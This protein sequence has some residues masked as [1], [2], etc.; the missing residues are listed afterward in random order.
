[1]NAEEFSY[2]TTAEL[3]RLVAAGEVTPVEL[4][5]C[6]IKRIEERNPSI[7]A[8]IYK[9]Y[10]TARAEAK[11]AE[12]AVRS[13]AL[14]GVLHGVPTLMKDLFDFKPGWKSTMGGIPALKDLVI[15]AYCVWAERV[16]AAGGIIVG[17]TNSPVMG[18]RGVTDNPLFGAT[19][20]PFDATRN[21]GGSSGGSAAAV[22]DG[23]VSFAEGTDGGGSIRIPSAWCGTYGYKASFG[24][25]PLV[26]RPNGFAGTQPTIAEGPITRNVKDAALVMT[27][28]GGFDPRDPYSSRESVDYLGALNQS[29]K[30]MRIAYSP[31]LDVFPI[32]RRVAASVGDAVRAFE[33]AGAHVEV[34][35]LGLSIDQLELARLWCRMIMPLNIAGLDAFAAGGL[36]LM[37]G[38]NLPRVYREWVEACRGMGLADLQRDNVMRTEVFDAIQG[39]FAHHDLLVTPT[40]SA[41]PPVNHPAGD[42]MGP[43]E[44]NG[45]DIDPSI[46][47]CLTYVT[48]FSHHPSASIPAGLAEG[49]PVGM[50]LIGPSGDDTRV[51]AAS[52]AYERLRPWLDTYEAC[53]RRK[54]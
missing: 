35:K 26:M 2:Q 33:E 12:A 29:I 10:E 3:A 7:N 15:N 13:G 25:V 19:R 4:V 32:D 51:L 38:D 17:K 14:L 47:F 42:T 22:A 46:G 40:L 11:V 24:R 54:I 18:F 20:N 30:G 43:S 31:D 1:M 53:R 23:L 5:E 45:I 44:V 27:A 50:Q 28:L 16:E 6:A 52:A 41:M 34:V 36:D 49:L 39:V 48:N 21:T 9:G 37:E 8:V